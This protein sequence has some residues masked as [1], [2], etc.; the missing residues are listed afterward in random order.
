L[1]RSP[2][3]P[4]VDLWVREQG[5]EQVRVEQRGQ[6]YLAGCE[7]IAHVAGGADMVCGWEGEES[8]TGSTCFTNIS[9]GSLYPRWCFSRDEGDHGHHSL[10]APSLLPPRH[11]TMDSHDISDEE[12]DRAECAYGARPRIQMLTLAF[13]VQRRIPDYIRL[14]QSV[15][16]RLSSPR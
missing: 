8:S 14:H 15:N 16:V 10:P 4:V 3:H 2:E 6:V 12:S 13:P 7:Q 11:S 9:G 1:S 5:R